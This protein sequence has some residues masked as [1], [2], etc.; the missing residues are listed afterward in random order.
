MRVSV[1]EREREKEKKKKGK[2]EIRENR[3]EG[4]EIRIKERET[5]KEK[6]S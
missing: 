5:C 3:R 4:V 2:K 6:E 1:C